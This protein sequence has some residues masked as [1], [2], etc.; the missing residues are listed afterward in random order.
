MYSYKEIWKN[1]DVGTTI[2]ELLERTRGLYGTAL[3]IY[4]EEMS[5]QTFHEQSDAVAASLQHRVQN[6]ED[7]GTAGRAV[8]IVSMQVSCLLYCVI[9]GVVKAGAVVVVTE[10]DMPKERLAGIREQTN[11]V[12][13]ITDALARTLLKEGR[14]L[15]FRPVKDSIAEDV[16]AVWYTSGS[17]GEPCG[18]RVIA[19]VMTCSLLPEPRNKILTDALGECKH[20]PKK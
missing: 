15:L 10:E 1:A 13:Q 17:T 20:L 7:A 12:L 18:I 6:R 19:P 2:H 9:T 4:G 11:A 16:F 14:R 5:Y 8:I 3:D